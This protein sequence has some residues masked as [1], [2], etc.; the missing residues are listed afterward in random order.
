M[1][2]INELKKLAEDKTLEEKVFCGLD[3]NRLPN[4]A[5][6]IPLELGDD[7]PYARLC[8]NSA[9]RDCCTYSRSFGI[10]RYCSYDPSE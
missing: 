7:V 4:H 10:H 8:F 3:T 5:S 6:F 2:E 1:I 9:S